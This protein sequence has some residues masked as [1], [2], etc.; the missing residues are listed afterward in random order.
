MIV[1]HKLRAAVGVTLV[2]SLFACGGG[3][4]SS[5]GNGGGGST[6]G[7]DCQLPVCYND[8]VN[9]AHAC[10]PTGACVEEADMTAPI[11]RSCYANGAK[12]VSNR[13]PDYSSSS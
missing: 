11:Y 10:V 1:D 3:S 6:T 5:N 9:S 13:S 2:T 12:V 4:S 7:S 8:F